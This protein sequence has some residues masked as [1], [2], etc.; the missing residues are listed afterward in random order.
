MLCFFRLIDFSC[1]VNKA[2]ID[3]FDL[4]ASDDCSR[5]EW[6]CWGYVKNRACTLSRYLSL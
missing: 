1:W 6:L 4:K 5:E 3:D 2:E